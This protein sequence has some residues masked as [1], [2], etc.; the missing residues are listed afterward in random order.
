MLP[1]LSV[2]DLQESEPVLF[3][4][5]GKP[6][7]GKSSFVA[8]IPNS[9]FLYH[10]A[11]HGIIELKRRKLVPKST[12]IWEKP[13]TSVKQFYDQLELVKSAGPAA[14]KHTVIIEGLTGIQTIWAKN[15]IDV[16]CQGNAADFHTFGKGT[17]ILKDRDTYLP[18][19]LRLISEL[20]SSGMNVVIT[21]HSADKSDTDSKT[22]TSIKKAITSFPQT[23]LDLLS[24]YASFHG[25]FSK[26]P[27][28]E[29]LSGKNI[30]KI[31]KEGVVTY[32]STNED[33]YGE[34]KNRYGVNEPIL[35]D[36]TP[37]ENFTHFCD[38]LKID[39]RTLKDL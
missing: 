30:V 1:E 38:V 23:L 29:K 10:S 25:V 3:I 27:A 35:L 31:G 18:K 13:F 39:P 19:L 12:F 7:S 14:G 37:Q 34:A 8:Q 20:R 28:P 2:D 33:A 4:F 21:G 16:V 6:G 24:G 5:I 17:K 15:A 26:R 22:G 32:I 11:D 36:G 9:I